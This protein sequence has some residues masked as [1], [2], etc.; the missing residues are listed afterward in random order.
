MLATNAVAPESVFH[1]RTP[2]QRAPT[3]EAA[4]SVYAVVIGINDYPGTATD[5]EGAVPDAEDMSDALA[6]NAFAPAAA[7]R[8]GAGV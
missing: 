8:R 6:L 5:L 3:T 2:I 7:I 4:K 1:D